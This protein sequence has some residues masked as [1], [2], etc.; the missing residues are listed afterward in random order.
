[1]LQSIRQE[2]SNGMT[3]HVH[4]CQGRHEGVF[5]GQL[6]STADNQLKP[7]YGDSPRQKGTIGILV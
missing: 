2:G 7:C 4:I 1:M 5:W 6:D 3:A